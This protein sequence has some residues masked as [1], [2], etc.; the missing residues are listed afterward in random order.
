MT[1]QA[2]DTDPGMVDGIVTK[3]DEVKAARESEHHDPEE[4]YGELEKLA[5]FVKKA[6]QDVAALRPDEVKDEYLPTA[7]DEL[8]AIV[9]STSKATHAI[10]DATEDLEALNGKYG[11][12]VDDVLMTATSKI[13]EACGFQDITGQRIGKVVKA[14]H[15]IEDRVDALL[16]AFGDEI[17]AYK[18][19]HP[20]DTADKPLTDADLLEG[21]QL[22]ATA[23]EQDD[24]DALLASFD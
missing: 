8:D 16:H 5:A 9:E 2:S 11:S 19:T 23:N 13:Y 10:M 21:P 14:L 20:K 22:K 6:R 15:S 18:E 7:S 3:A 17:K 1:S 4:L 24:I 12:E